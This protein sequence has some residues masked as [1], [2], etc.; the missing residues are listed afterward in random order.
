MQALTACTKLIQFYAMCSDFRQLDMD[1]DFFPC[2][3]SSVPKSF[4]YA[5][6]QSI[7][8]T[9]DDEMTEKEI[10]EMTRGGGIHTDHKSE[11]DEPHRVSA[12]ITHSDT[13]LL[14]CRYI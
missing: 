3:P 10:L 5:V 6:E 4:Y 9:D 7:Y 14:Y 13:H 8:D 2:I 12:V 11:T 1:E